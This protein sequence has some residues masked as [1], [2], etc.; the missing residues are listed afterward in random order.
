MEVRHAA[1]FVDIKVHVRLK[2]FALWSSV[3]FNFVTREKVVNRAGLEP[4]TR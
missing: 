4:A 3:M 1:A 2:L